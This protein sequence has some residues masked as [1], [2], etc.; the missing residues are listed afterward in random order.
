MTW[1]MGGHTHPPAT[2]GGSKTTY[3]D[4]NYHETQLDFHVYICVYVLFDLARFG[5]PIDRLCLVCVLSLHRSVYWLSCP[6]I[7]VFIAGGSGDLM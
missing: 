5:R 6:N 2:N 7:Y 3:D 1:W 4:T